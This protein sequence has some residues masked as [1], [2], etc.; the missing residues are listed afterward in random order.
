[1]TK[2]AGWDFSTCFRIWNVIFLMLSNFLTYR[3]LHRSVDLL[4]LK[5][6]K[7]WIQIMSLVQI[8]S[9]HDENSS[10]HCTLYHAPQ[11]CSTEAHLEP[12]CRNQACTL[13][14]SFG[15]LFNLN[16]KWT[17]NCTIEIQICRWGRVT[18]KFES[19]LAKQR[20]CNLWTLRN[21]LDHSEGSRFEALVK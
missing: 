13:S 16:F 4:V 8:R 10:L 5:T 7:P 9:F 2:R 6:S 18:V 11:A 21:Q 15:E 17:I 14:A 12:S 20:W 3:V 19:N 1:M